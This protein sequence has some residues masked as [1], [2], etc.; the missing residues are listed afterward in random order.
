MA[1]T[2]K[3]NKK[4]V[5]KQLTKNGVVKTKASKLTH[6]IMKGHQKTDEAKNNPYAIGMAQAEKS[7]GDTPPLKKSTINKAHKIAKAVGEDQAD[8]FGVSDA[9]RNPSMKNMGRD[10]ATRKASQSDID[11]RDA[12]KGLPMDP[13]DIAKRRKERAMFGESSSKLT[14]AGKIACLGCDEVS[15]SAAWQKNSNICP[16]CKKSSQGVAESKTSAK[17]SRKLKEGVLDDVDDDGFMAKRQL[18]DLAKYSVALHRMIQDTDNLE[19][20]VQAKITTAADYIDTVKH[21]MEYQ[22]V[23]DA[24]GMA[25]EIGFDDIADVEDSIDTIAPEPVQQEQQLMASADEDQGELLPQDIL[26]WAVLRNII[27]DVTYQ[28]AIGG[29]PETQKIW[30]AAVDTAEWIGPVDEVGSSDMSYW[31]RDFVKTAQGNGVVLDGPKAHVYENDI[32][33]RN[34]YKKMVKGLMGK[35]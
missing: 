29:T 18:Y 16:K 13:M 24:D 35:K 21:Y 30:N 27:T 26:Q 20:W 2:P 33:A 25:D 15:T 4:A 12:A 10:R 7:T 3:Y 23:R 19:P 14:E 31:L 1:Q 5:D 34:I 8:D 9:D 22:G 32:K 11:R 17:K 28:S 6:R